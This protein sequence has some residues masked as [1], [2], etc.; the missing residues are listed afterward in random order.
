M[1]KTG[2]LLRSD[3]LRSYEGL[4]VDGRPVYSAAQ[5]IRAA[6]LRQQGAGTADLFAIPQ[7]NESGDSVDWYAP[8]DG[9]VIP[10]SSASEDERAEA[11]A[12]LQTART[13]FIEKSQSLLAEAPTGDKELFARMLPLAVQVPDNS[14]VYIVN[15]K[16]VLTFWGFHPQKPPI[17]YDVIRD[18]NLLPVAAAAAIIPPEPPPPPVIAPVPAGRPFWWWLLWLLPLLL[19]LGLLFFGLRYCAEPVPTIELPKIEQPEQPLPKVEP[20]P[21]PEPLVEPEPEPAPEPKPEPKPVPKPQPTPKPEPK[22]QPVPKPQ[23]ETKE[24]DTLTIPPDAMKTGSTDFLNGRWRS[25]TGLVESG[26]GRPVEVEYEFK[27]GQGQKTILRKNGGNCTVG[28]QAR[29]VGGRLTITETGSAV[30]ADGTRF[31]ESRVDCRTGADGKAECQGQN[32]GGSD[33]YVEMRKLG[34]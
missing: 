12:L 2:P 18:L 30:C 23:P 5:Q 15:G 31:N 13:A 11:I 34:K 4:G 6:I 24:G 27:N 10:W 17:G 16:P 22:P 26:S 7:S 8:T 14:H 29:I 25:I 3:H 20:E 1:S 19:L 28:T 33:Y 9:P 32:K 21:E